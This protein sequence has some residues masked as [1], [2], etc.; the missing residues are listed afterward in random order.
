M[1]ETNWRLYDEGRFPRHH[2]R[3]GHGGF[4]ALERLVLPQS[5]PVTLEEMKRHLRCQD[6][7]NIL[8]D[9]ISALIVTAREWAENF[10]DRA[11]M[12]QTWRLTIDDGLML[13]LH[14]SPIVS[15]LSVKSIAKGGAR[16]LIDS[17]EYRVEESASISPQLIRTTPTHT[18]IEVEFVAGFSTAAE[19]PAIF[20]TA[21]KLYVQALF[22]LDQYMMDKLIAVAEASLRPARAC[23]QLS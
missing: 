15:I 20:K 18:L 4:F 22:D 14:R 9:D 3:H 1:Y 8:D 11:L 5:E 16:T 21:M 6:D 19:V 13:K 7:I 2:Q 10:T 17:S 12:E 23:L